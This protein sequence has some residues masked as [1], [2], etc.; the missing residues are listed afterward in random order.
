MDSLCS[1]CDELKSTVVCR[2]HHK[3]RVIEDYCTIT[4][5]GSQGV[6]RDGREQ[7]QTKFIGSNFA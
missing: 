4:T 2:V 1:I 5:L 7:Y 3:T 6:T